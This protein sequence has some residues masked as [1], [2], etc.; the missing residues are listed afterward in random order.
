MHVVI[1]LPKR[2][3]CIY[4][5]NWNSYSINQ[6]DDEFIGNCLNP[7]QFKL[8]LLIPRGKLNCCCDCHDLS[9]FKD[10][11]LMVISVFRK[12]L[13]QWSM[14]Q[15]IWRSLWL[16]HCCWI[17]VLRWG[18]SGLSM[19]FFIWWSRISSFAES[20]PEAPGQSQPSLSVCLVPLS[21][22]LR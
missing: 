5:Y 2:Y 20:A 9:C 12:D 6:L 21:H 13:L 22:W 4:S 11:L 10:S 1:H 15:Q 3:N 7:I 8:F 17:T 19:I 16:R 18:C 14:L